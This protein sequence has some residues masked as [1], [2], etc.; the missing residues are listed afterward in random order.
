MTADALGQL[1]LVSAICFQRQHPPEPNKG[2]GTYG[3]SGRSLGIASSVPSHF[4]L[5]R[6]YQSKFT[7]TIR[8]SRYERHQ[9]T[10]PLYH[11]LLWLNIGRR[12]DRFLRKCAREDSGAVLDVGCGGGNEYLTLVGPVIGIDLSLP[13]LVNARTIYHD[14]ACADVGVLPFPDDSFDYVVSRD[15]LGHIP[16]PDKDRTYGEL[17]RVLKPGGRMIHA[18]V[19]TDSRNIW[20]NFARRYP[21]LFYQVFI[22]RH[23]HFGLEM[24][25]QALARFRRLGLKPVYEEKIHDTIWPVGEYAYTFAD[26]FHGRSRGIDWLVRIDRLVA[27]WAYIRLIANCLLTPWAWL[28]DRTLPLDSAQGLLVC[29]EK[30]SDTERV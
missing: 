4:S 3:A 12:R 6:F 7:H 11:L 10:R 24:P 13:S 30:P 14:V 25:S 27:R 29:Y 5:R 16:L 17:L 21:S 26:A 22:E 2:D 19:E 23:G 15:V 8:L 28:L 20:F 9:W 1:V 18:A